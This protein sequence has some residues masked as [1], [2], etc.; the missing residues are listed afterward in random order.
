[1][2]QGHCAHEILVVKGVLEKSGSLG[3]IVAAAACPICFPKLA[4]I[5][6]LFG[7]GSL[8]AYEWQLLVAAQVLVG[9]AVAGSVLTYLRHRRRWILIMTLSGGVAF[10]AGL[11]LVGSE[12]IAYAGLALLVAGSTAELWSRVR[13]PVVGRSTAS[14]LTC[15]DCQ[16]R[17]REVMPTDA[18]QFF[19][20]CKGCGALLRPKAGDCCVFCSYG[21]VKCP[22]MQ[23]AGAA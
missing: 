14:V 20:E 1:M 4:L 11:Y 6:A 22:P 12:A 9:V 17:Q 19:Y 8:S 18:C 15:P 23:I 10:F 2:S 21:S 7:L 5:G 13:W 16:H 3:A